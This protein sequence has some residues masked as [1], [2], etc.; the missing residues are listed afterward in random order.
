MLKSAILKSFASVRS[1]P[2]AAAITSTRSLRRRLIFSS[3]ISDKS[4]GACSKLSNSSLEAVLPPGVLSTVSPPVSSVSSLK[5]STF[6]RLRLDKNSER[7][8]KLVLLSGIC[9]LSN[10]S[11]FGMILPVRP[12]FRSLRLAL[13][14]GETF[15]PR[16]VFCFFILDRL[17]ITAALRSFLSLRSSC[18][19]CGRSCSS[20]CGSCSPICWI[21]SCSAGISAGSSSG[22]PVLRV[23][24]F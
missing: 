9:A 20:C 7:S 11:V 23:N 2:R 6:L 1:I 15:S 10:S 5:F 3:R 19:S 4:S 8:S 18:P 12:S 24:S 22:L 21:S 14:F 17:L 16:L 13:F